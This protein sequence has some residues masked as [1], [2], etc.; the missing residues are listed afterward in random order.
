MS[1]ALMQVVGNAGI[2][3][4]LHN[5]SAM[6]I[7]SHDCTFTPIRFAT[8]NSFAITRSCDVIKSI[9]FK[10]K[11]A[12]LPG[13]WIYKNKWTSRAFE[14]IE[15]KI[16]GSTVLKYDKERLRLMNLIFPDDMRA[17]SRHLTFDY[18]LSE[19]MDISL[20][21]HETMFEFDIKDVFNTDGIPLFALQYHDVSVTF[22]LGDFAECIEYYHEDDVPALSAT[23]NYILECVP[24]SIGIFMDMEPRRA[25]AEM[26]HTFNTI[27]YEFGTIIV[28]ND[29]TCFRMGEDGI[30]SSEYLHITNEDG[31][32]IDGQ[33]LDSIEINLN[34][35]SRFYLSGFQ[36]RHFMADY[37]PHPVRDNSTS[38]NLYYISY[39]PPPQFS[40]IPLEPLATASVFGLN[41][42]RIDTH[43]MIL[44]YNPH[45]PLPPRIK[46]TIMRRIHN[47]FRIGNGTSDYAAEYSPTIPLVV[48]RANRREV[49][50]EVPAPVPVPVPVPSVAVISANAISIYANT[51]VSCDTIIPI[52]S[53]DNWCVITLEPILENTDV[54]QCQQ[55]KKLC[56]LEA[57]NE[58]FNVQKSCPHCRAS[59]DRVEF[60]VGKGIMDIDISNPL[61]LV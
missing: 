35:Q 50:N 19:R 11:M 6:N 26:Q 37:L 52:P 10:F 48:G 36:S 1:G 39:S 25:L 30:C 53:D 13:G 34:R 49:R 12:A 29:E 43:H 18:S 44:T 40:T 9:F 54:V 31:S 58:W 21:L 56:L 15:L 16:G 27:H 42:N 3:H 4:R 5:N 2:P 59:S 38:Q 32:E 8:N 61:I 51:F 14:S 23:D 7:I 24:Q 47:V 33:V 45:M 60:I 55:C 20:E 46:I 57:M 22:T 17:N 41:L 28:N